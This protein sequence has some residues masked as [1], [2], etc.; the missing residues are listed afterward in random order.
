LLSQALR[1]QSLVS[2][3]VVTLALVVLWAGLTAVAVRLSFNHT[4]TQR[5]RAVGCEVSR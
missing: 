1:G 3:D 2:P 5:H 4:A